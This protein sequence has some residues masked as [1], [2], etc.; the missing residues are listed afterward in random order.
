MSREVWMDEVER[1]ELE[2]ETVGRRG[3]RKEMEAYLTGA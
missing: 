3:Q 1:R 2:A